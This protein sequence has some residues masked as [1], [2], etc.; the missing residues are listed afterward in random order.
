M[1]QRNKTKEDEI[2]IQ[3]K[4]KGKERTKEETHKKKENTK[5]R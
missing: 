2:I 5:D 3:S 4:S 1:T